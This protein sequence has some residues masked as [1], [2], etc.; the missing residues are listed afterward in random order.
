M[1]N[2]VAKYAED[3]M[4]IYAECGGLMYLTRSIQD[5]N[6]VDHGTVGLLDAKTSMVKTTYV[7][8][9]TGEGHATEYSD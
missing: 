4:P 5:L 1:L 6:G 8:L 3:G 9:Y 7:E 2:S